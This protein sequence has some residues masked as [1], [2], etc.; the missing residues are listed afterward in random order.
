MKMYDIYDRAM[1]AFYMMLIICGCLVLVLSI[2]YGFAWVS[3][4]NYN[5][6][7]GANATPMEVWLVPHVITD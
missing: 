2:M 6:A 1:Y 5:N 3:A 7:T 4:E